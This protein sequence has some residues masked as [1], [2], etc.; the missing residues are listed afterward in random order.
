MSICKEV[1]IQICYLVEREDLESLPEG[2]NSGLVRLDC[3]VAAT[4]GR[5]QEQIMGLKL[6]FPLLHVVQLLPSFFCI[7][8]NILANWLDVQCGPGVAQLGRDQV[9]S[10]PATLA[11][12]TKDESIFARP[13]CAESCEPLHCRNAAVVRGCPQPGPG[14]PHHPSLNTHGANT[15]NKSR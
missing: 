15:A 13:V 6:M 10:R 14:L 5:Q 2:R 1:D 4:L 12:Q 3:W 7:L 11:A 8:I 9:P